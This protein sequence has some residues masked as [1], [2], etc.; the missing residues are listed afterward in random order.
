VAVSSAAGALEKAAH[1]REVRFVL[2]D[3]GTVEQYAK[4]ARALDE[5]AT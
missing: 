2:F 1:L 4:A 5:P 3:R